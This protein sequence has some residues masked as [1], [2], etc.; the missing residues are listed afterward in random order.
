MFYLSTLGKHVVPTLGQFSSMTI[1]IC[2]NIDWNKNILISCFYI[3][4]FVIV[5]PSKKYDDI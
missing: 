1:C 5:S 3:F 4:Y 2:L